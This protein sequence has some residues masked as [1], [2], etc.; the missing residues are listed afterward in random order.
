M[1]FESDEFII[2]NELPKL[3]KVHKLLEKFKQHKYIMEDT[4]STCFIITK[5]I[6]QQELSLNKCLNIFENQE[7]HSG[8]S[9][10]FI[11]WFMKSVK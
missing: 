5:P 3:W 8:F 11:L 2:A 7:L 6:F 4:F 1:I 10:L 9:I